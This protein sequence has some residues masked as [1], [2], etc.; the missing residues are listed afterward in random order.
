MSQTFALF[1]VSEETEALLLE[2]LTCA[3]L[4]QGGLA[5]E[6]CVVMM[7]L[8]QLCAAVEHN[9]RACPRRESQRLEPNA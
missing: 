1:F 7:L 3:G 2:M 6:L 4:P 5:C 9:P 8:G